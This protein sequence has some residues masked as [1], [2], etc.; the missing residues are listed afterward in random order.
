MPGN[1]AYQLE[2]QEYIP[3][4]IKADRNQRR[5]QQKKKV[6]EELKDRRRDSKDNKR[7]K[8]VRE[9]RTKLW[10]RSEKKTVIKS[11]HQGHVSIINFGLVAWF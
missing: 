4:N 2:K 11:V 8:K 9:N 5:R 7:Q 6:E 10:N 1:C 3:K